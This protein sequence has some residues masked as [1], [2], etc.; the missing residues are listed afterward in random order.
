MESYKNRPAVS[1]KMFVCVC[2]FVC[3]HAGPLMVIVEYCCHGNLS[4]FL[5]TK[6]EVFVCNTVGPQNRPF[7]FA[8]AL[9]RK[10]PYKLLHVAQNNK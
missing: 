4:T 10:G 5:K 9:V 1:L 8:R 3:V 6:R 2:A 7:C